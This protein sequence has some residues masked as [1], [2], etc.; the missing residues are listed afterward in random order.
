MTT[1]KES[2]LKSLKASH[3]KLDEMISE[4]GRYPGLEA[5]A[6]KKKKLAL[7]EKILEVEQEIESSDFK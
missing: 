1:T 4:L 6:L 5:K 3:A 2:Y 7:K